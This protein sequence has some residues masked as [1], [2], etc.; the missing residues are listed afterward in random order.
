M[1]SD[2][3]TQS[4]FI[5]RLPRE[6]R[7]T[8]YLEL[9]RSC[10]LRQHILWHGAATD[11]HFCRWSCNTEYRVED[12][13]Q[14]D[15]EKMRA[16]LGVPLGQEIL[17][18]RHDNA[19]LHCRRL[20][21]PWM[22]HWLCGER[23]F[24]EHGIAA[25]R[26]S[27]T[28]AT[29]CWKRGRKNASHGPWPSAYIPMLLS[30]KLIST[31]CLRSVYESTTFIFTD[32]RTIQMFFGHCALHPAIRTLKTGETPPAFFK[33]ARRFELSLSPDFPALLMCANYDLPG[34][35]RR[36][37]V[38]DFHWLRL[39]QF[40]NLQSVR[41]WIAARSV[42][43]GIEADGNLRGIKQF[44]ADALRDVLA[45]FGTVGSVTLSTPLSQSLSPEEGYV[46]VGAAPSVR[47]YKRGSGD[48]FHP[49]LTLIELG[50][51]FD[52][53]IYTSSTEEVR[54]ARNDGHHKIMKDV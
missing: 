39:G 4:T 36:H 25:V 54:L 26:G 38:Y 47:L 20:Q 41:I 29:L 51:V 12:E 8:V 33:H 7:D 16:E 13:L 31:E 50:C 6:V 1:P 27:S 5:S 9:W 22:N 15:I 10:G 2:P 35:P 14:R 34:I 30:C 32:M 43:C 52:G 46:S 28:S 44:N 48:R 53:L 3:Q 21:S 19:P 17:R 18:D 42:T 49:F 45:A 37:N 23:A 11:Q 40:Q 24:E